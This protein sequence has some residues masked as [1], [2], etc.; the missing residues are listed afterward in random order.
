MS[1][2]LCSG[3]EEIPNRYFIT[4][5]AVSGGRLE[6]FLQKALEVA[7]GQLCVRLEP[8]FMDFLLPC[9]SGQGQQLT[10]DELRQLHTGQPCHTS[11]DLG[12][13]YFTFLRDGQAHVVLF[14]SPKSL[15]E[16]YRLL[17][18][19]GVPLVLAEDASLRALLEKST[20]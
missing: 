3:I 19:L 20:P 4:D 16:K 11:K 18:Q 9:T 12:A 10:L 1:T 17:C 6:D 14:D 5:C 13:E 8:V 15:L 2:R 7:Q